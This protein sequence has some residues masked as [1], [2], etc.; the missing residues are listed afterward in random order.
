MNSAPVRLAIAGLGKI[1]RDQHVPALQASD[2]F[3][4]TATVDPTAEPLEGVAHFPSLAALLE[5]DCTVDAV[6]ICTPP[7]IRYPIAHQAL[8]AGL[9]VLLE[10]PPCATTAEVVALAQ[11]ANAAGG[12][13]FAAWHSR[14]AAGVA[15]AKEWLAGK[16]ILSV[17]I[18]WREDVRVWHPG[19]PWIWRAGGFGVF[20]PGINALSIAT[21]ILPRPLM[22]RGGTLQFPAN[23]EAPVS[24]Q[25]MLEDSAGLPVA[26]DLDFLQAGPQTWDIEVTTTEGMLT[27]QKGGSILVTPAGT[28]AGE[29]R[30]YPAI[31]DHFAQ[32]IRSGRSVVDAAPLQL[33]ADSFLRCHT[34]RVAE[35]H[36]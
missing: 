16:T 19:Q 29:D 4:L 3:A 26:L 30:E 17:A 34:K 36:E 25:V 9:H 1:A 2:D 8:T 12:T 10:K 27:L 23:C 24:G 33:V 18:T 31:Y 22:V 5:S 15:T 11:T 13:L 21:E 7:Q 20:D 14:Y 28:L 6:S 35:F 32:A